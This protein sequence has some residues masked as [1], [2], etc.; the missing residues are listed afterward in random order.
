MLAPIATKKRILSTRPALAAIDRG[1]ESG[2]KLSIS[3]KKP[4][5]PLFLMAASASNSKT[6]A[7]PIL[8]AWWNGV[9][10][11]PFTVKISVGLAP[12]EITLVTIGILFSPSSIPLTN[13]LLFF[14]EA[15]RSP[16]LCFFY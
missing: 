2:I 12:C 11:S 3:D 10:C 8:V 9:V 16:M 13:Q 5:T 6:L 14:I 7:L 15:F 4:L 1:A